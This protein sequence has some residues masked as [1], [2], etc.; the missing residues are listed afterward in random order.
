MAAESFFNIGNY[1]LCLI[2]DGGEPG[3]ST[4]CK[5]IDLNGNDPELVFQPFN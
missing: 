1:L 3:M 5:A 4:Q 2:V